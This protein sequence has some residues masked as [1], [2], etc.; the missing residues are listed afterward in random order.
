MKIYFFCD[1]SPENLQEDANILAE[2]F[3]Q[4]GISCYGNCNYWLSDP[5]S[6]SYLIQHDP[7]ILPDD[8]DIVIVSCTYPF[9]IKMKTF[10]VVERPLPK[11]LFH[12][13]RPYKTVYADNLDGYKTVSWKDSFRDFDIILR[14]KYNRRLWHPPN[15][16]P[17]VLGF[18]ERIVK[19][20]A[21]ETPFGQRQPSLLVNFG[22]S[23][24]YQH[25][26]R[27][28]AAKYFEPAV[29]E[30]LTLDR[31]IDDLSVAPEDPYDHLMWSQT[32]GRFCRDYYNRLK[33]SQAVSCFCGRMAPSL[34]YRGAQKFLSGGGRKVQLRKFFYETLSALDPRPERSVQWDSF[35]FW[36][37]L[38]AGA[39]VFH[40]D[41]E[42]YGVLLPVMPTKDNHYIG[43]R[44]HEVDQ[45]IRNIKGNPSL[46]E[47]VAAAGKQWARTHYSQKAMAERLLDHLNLS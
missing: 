47:D 8:C 39:A 14:S 44:F 9:W 16:V 32:G 6:E 41:L 3:R 29:G 23:H 15:M 18:D 27:M 38:C 5:E 13:S 2:G 46:L 33:T 30:I 35:R 28:L 11:S 21:G 10:E 7:A 20:T 19:A 37:G 36:E 17:W 1:D 24:P 42:Y 12:K 34:P 45:T 43:V 26:T 40:L 4:L 25:Q 22:G 31:T